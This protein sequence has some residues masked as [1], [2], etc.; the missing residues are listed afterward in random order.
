MAAKYRIFQSK[1]IPILSDFGGGILKIRIR[2]GGVH[3]T[4]E[5]M[6]SAILAAIPR[7][8][9]SNAAPLD[10]VVNS[11]AF[12]EQA[13]VAQAAGSNPIGTRCIY[14]PGPVPK[15]SAGEDAKCN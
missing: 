11:T 1:A 10:S 8:I 6:R 12:M 5:R 2:L 7:G 9:G 3:F 15:C 14:L 13:Y 4:A